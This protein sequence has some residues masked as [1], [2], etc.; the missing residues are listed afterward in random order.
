MK[1]EEA[2]RI[3]EVKAFELAEKKTQEINTKLT[4]AKR[5]KKSAEAALGGAKK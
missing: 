5:E 2:R 4:E 3:A 1:D